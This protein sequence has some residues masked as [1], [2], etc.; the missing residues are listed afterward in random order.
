M[1]RFQSS[2]RRTQRADFPLYALLFASP[3]GLW[4]LQLSVWTLPPLVMRAFGALCQ[5]A[6][7]GRLLDEL[8]GPGP[9]VKPCLRD[10]EVMPAF[11]LSLQKWLIGWFF[12]YQCGTTFF[13]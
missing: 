7:S 10:F 9:T 12:T 11:E 1:P 8:V 6:T 3:Q 5:Q 13:S 2:P 4:D